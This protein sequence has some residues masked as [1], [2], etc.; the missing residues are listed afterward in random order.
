MTNILEPETMFDGGAVRLDDYSPSNYFSDELLLPEQRP[1][2]SASIAADFYTHSPARALWRS[3]HDGQ[4]VTH[5][6]SLIFGSVAH[7]VIL[8]Q[9][10]WEEDIAVLPA[11]Y[12]DWRTNAAKAWRD[13]A[14]AKGRLP[15]KQ[16]E[17][18]TIWEM[19]KQ[20]E[21]SELATMLTVAGKPEVSVF[22]RCP[23]T[24][25]LCKVRWD[26]LP[27][28]KFL[29]A[30]YP[31]LDYKTT[32][33]LI[34]WPR[35]QVMNFNLMLRAALY[36]E[37]LVQLTGEPCNMAYLVQE[38][39]Q[40]HQVQT[41]YLMLRGKDAIPEHTE[42]I[43]AGRSQLKL[44]KTEFRECQESGKWPE[45]KELVMFNLDAGLVK[46]KRDEQPAET[47]EKEFMTSE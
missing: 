41:H 3:S 44:I 7:S 5:K 9:E 34:D 23:E 4:S 42:F 38:K 27:D 35:K 8:R 47:S 45:R 16:A 26:F 30:G 15:I 46:R 20:W 32:D 17:M 43:E 11:E 31:A 14:L 22:W 21:K 6:K 39:E 12:K 18:E 40:P 29:D 24:Y 28:G 36:Y 37:S 19:R 33:T 2:L 13:A 1:A 25:C 10:G